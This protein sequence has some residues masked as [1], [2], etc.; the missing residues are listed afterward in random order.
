MYINNIEASSLFHQD[1][2]VLASCFVEV[3]KPLYDFDILLCVHGIK[4]LKPC[5]DG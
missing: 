3:R 5:P 1:C 2:N 4:Q